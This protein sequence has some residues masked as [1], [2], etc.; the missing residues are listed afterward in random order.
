MVMTFALVVISDGR[1]TYTNH[2]LASV[3]NLKA[4]PSY[5]RAVDDSG[6]HSGVVW[7]AG[8]DV[9]RH[10]ERRGLAA[11][12]QSA[13][14]GLPPEVDYVFHLEADFVLPEPVDLEGMAGVLDA[15]PMLANLVLKRQ[16]GC[17]EEA[18][19]GGIIECHP[20]DYTDRAGWVEHRRCFS[21]N[22]CLIPR[23]V[24]DM[25]WPD[26]NEAGQTQRLVEGGWTFGFWGGRADPPKVCHIGTHRAEGWKP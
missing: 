12:V 5:V 10:E 24:V 26:S 8:W 7:P 23:R 13:W 9:V 19:A 3:G 11:A 25:G 15:N 2:C 1:D 20:D 4:A 18:A 6:G 14:A 17:P 16:P 21:L 22:P